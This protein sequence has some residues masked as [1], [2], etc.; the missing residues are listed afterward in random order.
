MG[1]T[2]SEA[3]A[4][5]ERIAPMIRQEA[6][7]RGYPICST[8][9]A[10][11]IVEGAAGTSTLAKVHHN[12]FG[13]KTGSSWKGK[14]ARLR[15]KEEYTKGHLTEIYADFRSYANDIEGISG[16]YQF[17]SS[18]RYTNL[19]YAKDYRQYAEYLKKDGWATSSTYRDNLIS[20]VEK[21]GLTKYDIAGN[22]RPT[23][24]KGDHGGY[25]TELQLALNKLGYDLKVDGVFGRNT[26][27]AVIDFQINHNLK[28]DG[29][30]GP[31]TWNEL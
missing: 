8:V 5:I 30:V 25:V 12:H 2:E 1:Y 26:E 29:I 21:Y 17:I 6:T 23:I 22:I 19:K 7:K 20:K 9:I 10:Q 31:K 3:K 16:Y 24:R 28:P 13:M 11:A 27:Q 15:T 18:K 4:F 14:V